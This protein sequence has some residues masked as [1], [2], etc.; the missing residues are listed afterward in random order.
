MYIIIIISHLDAGGLDAILFSSNLFLFFFLLVI[1]KFIFNISVWM[2]SLLL[3]WFANKIYIGVG[4]VALALCSSPNRTKN[5]LTKD[6]S[7]FVVVS[8]FVLL[9]FIVY[10]VAATD[11]CH[12][13]MNLLVFGCFSL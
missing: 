1:D 4:C 9:L 5:K 7:N 8:N 11:C 13:A 3:L 6:L 10:S 2:W 12:L